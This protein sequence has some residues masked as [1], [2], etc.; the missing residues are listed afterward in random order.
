MS[1]NLRKLRLYWI[2][3]P[4]PAIFTNLDL[5][6]IWQDFGFWPDLQNGAHN[7]CSVLYFNYFRKTDV[8][9]PGLLVTKLVLNMLPSCVNYRG[10]TDN[11]IFA[12]GI[13]RHE[14]V[15]G[16]IHT[17]VRSSVY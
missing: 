7:Y 1:F 2:S 3:A 8:K 15:Y 17:A 13:V 4:A 9:L 16:I 5:V 12:D 14:N 6:K 10:H 11:V